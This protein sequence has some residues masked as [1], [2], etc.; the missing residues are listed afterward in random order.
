M[1][2]TMHR[3][4]LTA[5]LSF[6][7]PLPPQAVYDYLADFQKHAEWLEGEMVSQ[8]QTSPG[9]VAVGTTFRT[10]EAM[11][12]GSNMKG[13]TYCEITELTPP[14]RIA[15]RAHTEAT[16]GMMAMRSAWSFDIA[17]EGSGSRV[18]Q[19]FAFD[20][21]NRSSRIFMAVFLPI[22]DG[23]LGGM[24]ASPKNVRK[25][26]EALERVLADKARA[27]M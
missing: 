14:S 19:T 3:E 20:P 11:R 27:G 25:H 18:T 12:P 17:P 21:P 9:P 23:L 16:T 26:A 13:V 4:G 8:E 2:M 10:T 22:V 7:T 15:W 24:G 6:V 1:T 5:Q